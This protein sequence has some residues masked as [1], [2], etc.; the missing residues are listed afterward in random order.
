VWM[1]KIDELE[2]DVNI[3]RTVFLFESGTV[4]CS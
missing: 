2:I 1:W 4:M 3:F